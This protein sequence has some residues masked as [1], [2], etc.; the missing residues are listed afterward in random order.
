MPTVRTGRVAEDTIPPGDRV[1]RVGEYAGYSESRYN[2][3]IRTSQYIEAGD[4]TRLAVDVYRPTKDGT[5]EEH[6]LPV[7]WT[8]KRYLRATV[9][10]NGDLTTTLIG[11]G[12]IDRPAARKLI[13]HGYVLAAADM[14]GTG[15]SFGNW[16]ECSDPAASSDGYV[17]NEWLATQ[18]WCDGNTGM[19]GVSYEGRMQLNIASA[20]PPSLKA[21][22]PEV[23]PFDWY[24]IIQE[25]GIYGNGFRGIEQHFR[26]CDLNPEVAPVDSDPDGLLAAEARHGHDLGNDYSAVAGKWPFRDSVASDGSQPWLTNDGVHLVRGI[27]RSGVATYH[28]SG[29]FARV[30]I[31]QLLWFS[32]LARSATA[33]RHRILMGPWPQGGVAGADA[34]ARELWGTETLRFMDYWLKGIDNGIMDEPPVVYATTDSTAHRKVDR[35][36]FAATWP[37]TNAQPTQFL[38]AG[39]PSGSIRSVND[40][41]LLAGDRGPETSDPY[42]VDY[43]VSHPGGDTLM[44]AGAGAD[45]TPYSTGCITY[46]TPA[47]TAAVEVTG[48]PVVNLFVSSTAP[49][50]DFIVHLLDV[51]PG[52]ASTFV[53]HKRIRASHRAVSDPP[54]FY[55]DAPW[56]TDYEADSEPMRTDEVTE[57]AFDLLP[58]SYHFRAGHRIRVSI[59]CADAELYQTPVIEPAPTV[60]FH[61]SEAHPS[62]LTLP[63]VGA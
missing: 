3:W 57:L 1:S 29:W 44:G 37:L 27:E 17:V 63:V 54:F 45:F 10:D 5:V 11:G 47:L 51:E 12:A 46:T 60:T 30:G 39:G 34:E 56:H 20:A 50:G 24:S 6:P 2:G 33:D 42:V 8:A 26:A 16:R 18:P 61:R 13:T 31:D 28:S 38:F 15:A 52:G 21:I 9:G 23:S 43:T 59:A 40:G 36:N 22:V 58:T 4:G 7:C 62:R 32:N 19:F 53:T 48:H 35:W 49:D 14:R 55:F 41:R 25:G